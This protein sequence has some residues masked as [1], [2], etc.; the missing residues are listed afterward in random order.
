MRDRSIKDAEK[1]NKKHTESPFV[2]FFVTAVAIIL[3]L[4]AAFVFIVFKTDGFMAVDSTTLQR[5]KLPSKTTAIAVIVKQTEEDSEDSTGNPD[6]GT[7]NI[8]GVSSDFKAPDST[9]EWY[10]KVDSYTPSSNVV[11]TWK[12]GNVEYH[13]YD[14]P[15][16]PGATYIYYAQTAAQDTENFV[17]SYIDEYNASTGESI[18][19]VSYQNAKVADC[20]VTKY[21]FYSGGETKKYSNGVIFE[22]DGIPCIGFAPSPAMVYPQYNNQFKY[23][24][25]LSSSTP[26]QTYYYSENGT[27]ANKW[28]VVLQNKNNE[29][30]LIYL[31]CFAS[32]AKGHS[33]PG[34]VCQTNV[35]LVRGT[36]DINTCDIGIDNYPNASIP[37]TGIFGYIKNLD[38]VNSGGNKTRVYFQNNLELCLSSATIGEWFSNYKLYAVI[39]YTDVSF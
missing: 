11:Q 35:A 32:D 25:W 22:T 16:W 8:P 15:P 30:D 24:G 9:G 10:A 13:A 36:G 5:A 23:N 7:H 4:S 34:G 18:E 17:N 6:T 21:S 3:M 28:C 2:K 29:S 14:G 20:Y 27:E 26:A 39:G 1:H 19:H 31:P 38:T 33:F 12:L 37:A